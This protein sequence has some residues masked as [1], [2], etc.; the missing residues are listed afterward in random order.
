[1]KKPTSLL[2]REKLKRQ[3]ERK[4][5][6]IK[7]HAPVQHTPIPHQI[8]SDDGYSSGEDE[9]EWVKKKSILETPLSPADFEKR[10]HIRDSRDGASASS[11][12]YSFDISNLYELEPLRESFGQVLE[13]FN[14]IDERQGETIE[15]DI[16]EEEEEEIQEALSNKKLRKMKQVPV[17]QLKQFAKHPEVVEWEDSTAP[18]PYFLVKLKCVRNT[19]PVPKH[20]SRKR[21]YLAGKRG[22]IK[23]PF[24]LPDFL[25]GLGIT[26]KRQEILAAD[27]KKTQ[28]VKAREKVHPKLGRLPLDYEKL[29]DAFF[30]YQTKP[31]LSSYGDL[32]H[33]GKEL[34][35]KIR[36]K[37][38]GHLSDELRAAL[39]MGPLTPPPWLFAMQ[40]YGPPP[41]Y[42]LMRIPGLNA[43]LPPGAQWGYHPGGW[44]KPPANLNELGSSSTGL[45]ALITSDLQPKQSDPWGELEPE[46]VEEEEQDVDQSE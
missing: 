18:D 31:H 1:M 42:P 12:T 17:A 39:G 14:L 24:E 5:T 38:P 16:Y 37:R 2:R 43:P 8:K 3:K 4:N 27:A 15:E 36:E 7:K 20:W 44:G 35:G 32:Y 40:R 29:Y 46:P 33:E 28:K 30:K 34:Q 41:P 13:K 23:P 19:I 26:E 10:L 11:S 21:R 25:K 45:D 9:K 22:F 6:A